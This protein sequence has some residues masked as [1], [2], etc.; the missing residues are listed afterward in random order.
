MAASN[1]DF[2]KK[3]IHLEADLLVHARENGKLQVENNKLKDQLKDLQ[4]EN[5][6]EQLLA[7]ADGMIKEQK[8]QIEKLKE[9]EKEMEW[10][11]ARKKSEVDK[12]KLICKHLQTAG[13][14]LGRAFSAPV[15]ATPPPTAA[16]GAAKVMATVDEKSAPVAAS[17]DDG[18]MRVDCMPMS[19]GHI[20]KVSDPTH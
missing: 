5:T 20:H 9:N 4:N 7:A 18:N 12:H 1:A 6:H 16:I 8:Q 15:P 14:E 3:V 2:E 10:A 13:G 17:D 19:A 11:L